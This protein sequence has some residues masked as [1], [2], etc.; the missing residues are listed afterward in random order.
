MQ[1]AEQGGVAGLAA[2]ISYI[3]DDREHANLPLRPGRRCEGGACCEA[4]S[5][6]TFPTFAVSTEID[7]E[8]FPFLEEFNFND[9]AK[10]GTRTILMFVRLIE[11]I[12]RTI[13]LK[14]GLP[15]STVL[16]LQA[17]SRKYTAG[18]KQQGG[19]GGEG[20]HV[21]FVLMRR[22]TPAI[23]TLLCC[24]SVRSTK[25]LKEAHFYGTTRL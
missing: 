4:C 9:C 11:R 25:T 20:E 3:S 13:A 2:G 5:R 12:R 8:V 19:G 21:I 1:P 6:V 24:T 10:Y 17:Y 15:L 22:H 23:T 16:P 14:Y 7:L 18:A